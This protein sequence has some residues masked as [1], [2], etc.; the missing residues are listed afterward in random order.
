MYGFQTQNLH[1][2]LV[3]NYIDHS[4]VVIINP[5][6][7]GRIQPVKSFNLARYGIPKKKKKKHKI[8]MLEEKKFFVGLNKFLALSW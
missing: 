3:L 1:E 7:V 5:W 8:I 6:L 4:T 2:T